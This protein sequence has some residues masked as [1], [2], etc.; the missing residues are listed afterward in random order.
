[1]VNDKVEAEGYELGEVGLG[2]AQVMDDLGC[3]TQVLGHY[4]LDHK[5]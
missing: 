1:M 5:K 2:T 4:P 3:H